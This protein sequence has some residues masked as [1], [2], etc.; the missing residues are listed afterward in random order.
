G[1]ESLI[2]LI[3]Q[4]PMKM[5][6]EVMPEKTHVLMCGP[7]RIRSRA[8]DLISAGEEFMAAAWETAAM[9]G[10]APIATDGLEPSAY[11]SL[12]SIPMPTSWH[13]SPPGMLEAG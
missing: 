7:E 5:L 13:I 10:S 9:G 4:H 1:M 6:T 8:Q 12:A 2:P 3:S 11:R